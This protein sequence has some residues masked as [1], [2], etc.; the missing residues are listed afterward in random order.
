MKGDRHADNITDIFN[1]KTE[2]ASDST[3]VEDDKNTV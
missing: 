3:C 1:G 2:W